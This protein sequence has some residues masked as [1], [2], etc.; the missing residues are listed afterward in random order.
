MY[1]TADGLPSEMIHCMVRDSHGFLWFCTAE[2][3]SRFDGH[4]FTTFGPDQGAPNRS[5]ADFLETRDGELWV[6]TTAGLSRFHPHSLR[7]AAMAGLRAPAVPLF[8]LYR[9]P[10]GPSERRA[11]GL[12]ES[13]DGGIWFLTN[14]ALFRFSRS[15]KAFERID[16][17]F[18]G[19]FGTALFAD[20]DGSL[21]LGLENALIHRE[22]DGRLEKYGLAEGLPLLPG[23]KTR[24]S[25]IYRDRRE[26]LWV[27]TWRGL[28]LLSSHPQPGKQSV[29]RIY[30]DQDGLAGRVVDSVL[31]THDGKLWVGVE[32]GLSE[33]ILG[34][35][36]KPDRFLSYTAQ[37]QLNISDASETSVAQLTEDA[38]GNL[39]MAAAGGAMRLAR[40]G[41]TTY[42]TE[43]GVKD[44]GVRSIQEDRNGRLVIIS[45]AYRSRFLQVFHEG[46]FV[47]I[48]PL[49]PKWI[50]AFTWGSGQIHTQ[51]HTGI[52]WVAT[53]SGL[54]RYPKVKRVEELAYTMAQQVYTQ[55]DGLPGQEIFRIYEDSSGDMWISVIGAEMT[56]RWSRAE[57]RF[58][59]FK[60][61][62]DGRPLGTPT[63]FAEDRSGGVWMGFYWHD[64][65]RYH[66]GHFRVFQAEDGLP[67]GVVQ[68]LFLDHAGRMW[69]AT[70]AGLARIDNPEAARPQFKTYN[71]GSGLSSNYV[72]CVTE[73][74]WGRIY[75]GT[76]SGVDRI[77]P[78]TGRIRHYSQGE[79]IRATSQAYRDHQG[80][81][82]FASAGLKRLVPR[83]D[84]GSQT[85][86]PIRIARIAV[87]G[88]DLPISELG[89]TQVEGLRLPVAQTP[90]EI[91][92]ASVSFEI[93]ES[94][95]YQYKLDAS[96]WG[97]PVD[98]PRVTYASISPGKYR[99]EVRAVNTDG[100]T[101]SAPA[102]VAFT[103]LP[104]WFQSWW[105]LSSSVVL[106][107]LSVW[108]AHRYR[109]RQA[110]ELERVRTRIATD[111]HD[112]VGSSLTQIAI[113]SEVAQRHMQTD[114]TQAAAPLTRIADLSRELVD[115]MSDIVWAINPQ[116]DHVSDLAYR[117][118]R[119]ASELLPP[120]NIE[121]EFHAPAD[122]ETALGAE[123]RRQVFLVFKECV[124]NIVRH[125]GCKRAEIRLHTDRHCLWLHVRDDGKGLAESGNGHS[126]GLAS[127]EQRVRSL[128]GGWEISSE[129]G[130]GT[131]I[132][133]SIPLDRE[134]AR[135]R[136]LRK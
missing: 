19:G 81:L 58:Q 93:G 96:E 104:P 57:D 14:L 68:A 38:S 133:V 130:K 13:T 37:K 26:H 114:A 135:K 136:P 66:N 124:N 90:M 103:I 10:D 54:C 117:M 1:S 71:T 5:V 95:R 97:P 134:P 129:P 123:I 89:E 118:R 128:R 67:G 83:P 76:Q 27:G 98:L 69:V 49:V 41:F 110:L 48:T 42:T 92:F 132:L 22:P 75:A 46:G 88:K 52:W 64:L 59:S 107:C 23:G 25:T 101:S 51:D 86:P 63:A 34:T 91:E 4:T 35:G 105:F 31:E 61:G 9:L 100:L 40:G 3:L 78:E 29:E 113:L 44:N 32:G 20:R 125:S 112:D 50:D 43:D 7:G 30:N 85:R 45:G 36:G 116:R 102:F 126:H 99:F 84:D 15:R 109:L 108:A 33:A 131:A 119:F 55:K 106:L 6:A 18:I 94:I 8:E 47:A 65:A 120:R 56:T 12:A 70:S 121:L 111:L 127:M 11:V 74:T 2:G 17:P 53:S 24:V 73:D 16:L 21:W 82:W 87:R 72:W 62:D 122:G 79:G 115:S 77:D 28:C 39:W 80:V 60:Q